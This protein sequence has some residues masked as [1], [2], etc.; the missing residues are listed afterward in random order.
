MKYE[1]GT[2]S[3]SEPAGKKKRG[4]YLLFM[5]SVGNITLPQGKGYM[6]NHG[7]P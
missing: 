3:D 1:F 5:Q 6:E 7:Y 4:K 2:F